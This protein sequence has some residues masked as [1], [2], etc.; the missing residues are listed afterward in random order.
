MKYLTQAKKDKAIKKIEIA[1]DKMVDLQDMG[2]GWNAVQR[3][4][5]AL[6]GL[7]VDIDTEVIYR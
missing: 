7:R 1:I 5:D 2:I 3:I 6:N 4:L